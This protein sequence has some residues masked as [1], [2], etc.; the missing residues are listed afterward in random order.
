MDKSAKN[1]SFFWTAPLIQTLEEILSGPN[2]FP[3]LTGG[4]IGIIPLEKVDNSLN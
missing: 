3:W 2:S 1:V 4:L